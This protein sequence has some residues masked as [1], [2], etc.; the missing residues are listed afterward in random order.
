[1]RIRNVV[2]ALAATLSMAGAVS[3]Q[4]VDHSNPS[5]NN[6]DLVAN[7]SYDWGP[8]FLAGR[9]RM[10]DKGT[11][12]I[13][14]VYYQ[15]RVNVNQFTNSFIFQ[16]LS[17]GSTDTST[18][19][20]NDSDGLTFT[21]QNDGLGALGFGGGNLGYGEGVH[22]SIAVK[23]DTVPN[24]WDK[25]PDPSY[26][27][28]GLYTSGQTPGGGIDLLPS[29]INLRSQ[30]PMRVDMQYDGTTLV[31]VITDMITGVVA[32]Q[33]Y[34]IDI[35]RVVGSQTAFIGFTAATGDGSSAQDLL[36]WYWASPPLFGKTQAT[37]SH[38]CDIKPHK[39]GSRDTVAPWPTEAIPGPRKTH[40]QG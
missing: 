29:G 32:T 35:P 27:S 31:V 19:G 7:Q 2:L 1:M 16:I 23:F 10:T 24:G 40:Q 33:Y 38:A 6:A 3:A 25:N 11:G 36:R 21:I 20:G 30:H 8:I 22:H 18:G 26:S 5:A 28:T 4:V 14:S 37:A 13:S 12:E 9:C 34:T 39:A 17:G 15:N